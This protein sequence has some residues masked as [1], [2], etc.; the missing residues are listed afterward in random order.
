[1]GYW[2]SPTARGHGIATHAT[3]LTADWAFADLEIERL[4]LTCGPENTASQAVALRC[5]FI[6]EGVLRAY[7]PFNRQRRDTVVYSLLPS[8]P[9]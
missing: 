1:V 4:E 8:D 3:R 6:R 9:R 7:L 5:G 2:L